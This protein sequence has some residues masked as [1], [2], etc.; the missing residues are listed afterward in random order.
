MLISTTSANL[1]S[2]RDPLL[3]IGKISLISFYNYSAETR[4]YSIHLLNGP[5]ENILTNND[6]T[7]LN[8]T[9]F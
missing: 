9:N 7:R 3:F 1:N 8:Q 4:T 5:F 2:V 6:H